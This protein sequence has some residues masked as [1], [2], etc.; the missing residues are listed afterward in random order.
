VI[1]NAFPLTASSQPYPGLRSFRAEEADIFFGRESQTA[2][3]LVQLSHSRCVAIVG[4][5]GCG[6]SSLARAG[7][8]API[9]A[10]FLDRPHARWRMAEMRPGDRPLDNLA[11][12]LLSPTCLGERFEGIEDAESLMRSSLERGPLGLVDLLDNGSYLSDSNLLLLVDQFEEVFTMKSD[13][14]DAFV[15]LLVRTAMDKRCQIDMIITMRSDYLGEAETYAG[16]AQLLTD[17]VFIIAKLT[18]RERTLAI[19]GPPRLFGARVDNALTATLLNASQS[20]QSDD[21]PWLQHCLSRVWAHAGQNRSLTNGTE[22]TL[23][24]QDFESVGGMDALSLHFKEIADGLSEDR[25]ILRRIVKRVTEFTSDDRAVRRP[26]TVSEIARYGDLKTIDVLRVLNVVMQQSS[27]FFVATPLPMSESSLID[28]THEALIRRCDTVRRWV[29]HE[30][31]KVIEFRRL[32]DRAARH[33]EGRGS[34]LQGIE[35]E[36][37]QG[38]MNKYNPTEAWAT[39]YVDSECYQLALGYLDESASAWAAEAAADADREVELRLSK[40]NELRSEKKARRLYQFLFTGLLIV[41]L[42]LGAFAQR[43]RAFREKQDELEREKRATRL[44]NAVREQSS[45]PFLHQALALAAAERLRSPEAE[46]LLRTTLGRDSARLD[47][48]DQQISLHTVSAS[49]D[50][51]EFVVTRSGFKPGV[52]IYR[53]DGAPLIHIEVSRSPFSAQLSRDKKWLLVASFDSNAYLYNAETGAIIRTFSGHQG[54]VRSACF[55]PDDGS[56][57]TASDDRTAKLWDV[58]SGRML[59]EFKNHNDGVMKARFI[60]KD[61][62]V[63]AAKD[64]V[65]RMFDA[66]D[67]RLLVA[68]PGHLDAVSDIV[69]SPD[70]GEFATSSWD[71]VVK[72]WDAK[73]NYLLNLKHPRKVRTVRYTPDG[74]WLLT[75]CDDKIIRLWPRHSDEERFRWPAAKWRVQDISFIPGTTA[76]LACSD[77]LRVSRYDWK[78][79]IQHSAKE[80]HVIIG[81]EIDNSPRAMAMERVLG[82]LWDGQ[83]APGAQSYAVAGDDGTVK[84]WNAASN[85]LLGAVSL[86]LFGNRSLA[87]KLLC[88]LSES[89]LVASDELGGIH[90]L[91]P[92]TKRITRSYSPVGSNELVLAL[93][94]DREHEVCFALTPHY[95]VRYSVNANPQRVALQ[96]SLARPFTGGAYCPRTQ[97]IALACGDAIYILNREGYNIEAKLRSRD[98]VAVHCLAFSPDGTRVIFG[99][100]DRTVVSWRPQ[101]AKPDWITQENQLNV[102]CLEFD[103]NGEQ[104]VTASSDGYSKILSAKTGLLLKTIWQPEQLPGSALEFARFSA[105]GKEVLTGGDDWTAAIVPVT[106]NGL[107]DVARKKVIYRLTEAEQK[108]FEL[109]D[110]SR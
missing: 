38:W 19:E 62:I 31:G 87:A 86:P 46:D 98:T 109:N 102:L 13:D 44:L 63:T 83:Y 55:S 94:A 28:I 95:L 40:E 14:H 80:P 101:A 71:H 23:T 64:N 61:R 96:A 69:A 21:L 25:S 92:V 22:L 11:R 24:T 9:V 16:L 56:V 97:K 107:L 68:F 103:S 53:L 49:R 57:L 74:K 3:L 30:R 89:R 43:D 4:P 76:F 84:F 26:A 10:G 75:V 99:G 27:D 39:T 45:K 37:F 41:L 93:F 18:R 67:G 73:G 6:K 66:H 54:P 85:E 58:A 79:A 51:S 36:M 88:Y 110:A 1:E 42:T 72:I 17:V 2:R 65:A 7:L 52:S 34:L 33:R 59:L 15:D 91:D 105:D 48:G 106:L 12:A 5:S 60:D 8:I 35:L 90:F 47:Q 81:S 20:I 82:P 104:I 29:A 108:R 70:A 100:N 32:I 77:D 50:G 78:D